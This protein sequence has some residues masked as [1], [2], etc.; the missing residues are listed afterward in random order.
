MGR[1]GGWERGVWERMGQLPPAAC[2]QARLR[3]KI[4]IG[5]EEG[6]GRAEGRERRIA[7]HQASPRRRRRQDDVFY[8]LLWWLLP[9]SSD[10]PRCSSGLRRGGRCNNH[11]ATAGCSGQRRG[12]GRCGGKT[13]DRTARVAAAASAAPTATPT[14]A[15]LVLAW[16]NG[17]G[18]QPHLDGGDCNGSCYR[19]VLTKSPC[20]CVLQYI[21]YAG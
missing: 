2:A 7:A 14:L 15:G 19:R 16:R 1:K 20:H 10:S 11:F 5:C 12:G 4:A 8:F 6:D 9:V 3:W 21:S 18:G 13:G 17:G